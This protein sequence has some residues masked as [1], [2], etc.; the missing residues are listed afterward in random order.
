MEKAFGVMD[1]A[2]E[3]SKQSWLL[4]VMFSVKLVFVHI[5]WVA[6]VSR[7]IEGWPCLWRTL[8]GRNK[9][10]GNSAGNF[11][12]KKALHLLSFANSISM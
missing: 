7:P 9:I 1:V 11:F 6:T 12:V 8:L 10:G 3:H 2:D 5:R 4:L